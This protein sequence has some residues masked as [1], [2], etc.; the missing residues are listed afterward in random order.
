[1]ISWFEN[2][3]VPF[4]GV[5]LAL[6]LLAVVRVEMLTNRYLNKADP[7]LLDK[8]ESREIVKDERFLASLTPFE[9]KIILAWPFF[10]WVFLISAV[11]LMAVPWILYG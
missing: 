7:E 3:V 6:S 2:V 5:T 11:A 8:R 9:A 1:M 10:S 4:A